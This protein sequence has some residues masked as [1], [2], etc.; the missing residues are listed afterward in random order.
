MKAFCLLNNFKQAIQ[1]SERITGKQVNLPIL[2]NILIRA[3]NDELVIL[4]TNLELGIK[5]KINTK[6]Q[7]DG[8]IAVPARVLS[9]FLANLSQ[10]SEKIQLEVRNQTL[11]LKTGPHSASIKGLN[12]DEFP[13]IPEK[14][15]TFLFKIDQFSFKN[16]LLKTFFSIGMAESR[17]ELTG[18]YL[19]F[20][21]KHL[22]MTSTDSFRLTEVKLPLSG[23]NK[24]V[25]YPTVGENIG[26][27]IIPF[28]TLN[29]IARII[30]GEGD[31][32]EFYLNENQAFFKL[33]ST[34][35]VSRLISGKYPDY[36]QVI[37]AKFGTQAVVESEN[38]L[39]VLRMA[40][41][42]S[43]GRSGEIQLSL[44]AEKEKLIINSES[45]ELGS[46]QS[47]ISSKILG[48]KQN[49]TLNGK[50]LMDAIQAAGSEKVALM[51]NNPAAP[52]G[53]RSV[54][55][56]GKIKEDFVCIIMP[57]KK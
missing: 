1:N 14:K 21:E 8:E 11:H 57:I 10:E 3:K 28:S 50:Y 45:E 23:E 32:I 49:L 40:N 20:G 52:I 15:G 16:A 44:E 7:K 12:T 9:G 33:G 34:Q 51:V 43:G 26:S 22:V 29:E 54:S 25:D 35:L 5:S 42:F 27:V 6:V 31:K 48:S 55:G 13:I 18:I 4:A 38:F 46:N 17:Q 30:D 2:N 41:V 53:I 36:E 24:G 47:E 56:E 39:R 37:P 19:G